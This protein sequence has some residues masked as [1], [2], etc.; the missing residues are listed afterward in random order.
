[1][2]TLAFSPVDA[3]ADRPFAGGPR[4]AALGRPSLL[5][6]AVTGAAD[7]IE[8]VLVGGLVQPVLRAGLTLED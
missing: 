7:R 4:G 3:L 8:D 2:R 6:V 1:M 5:T